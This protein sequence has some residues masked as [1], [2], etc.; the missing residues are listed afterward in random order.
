MVGGCVRWEV[1][2]VV[3]LGVGGGQ[4]GGHNAMLEGMFTRASEATDKCSH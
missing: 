2:V 3:V 1:V 4:G